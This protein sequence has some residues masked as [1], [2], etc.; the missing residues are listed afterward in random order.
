FGDV[1]DASRAVAQ[2]GGLYD[3]VD[4]AHDDFADGALRKRKPPHGDHRFYAV[5][6]FART[7]GVDGSHRSVMTRVH[8][9]QQVEHLRSANLA[10]DDA[11]GAHAQAVLDEVTHRDLA[12]ALEIGW[13]RLE[14][15]HMR[16]LK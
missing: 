6:A 10:H 16:L 4:R 11:L 3:D 12:F 8:R 9:L 1:R 15:H 13:P 7:V 2:A 14:A 5:E